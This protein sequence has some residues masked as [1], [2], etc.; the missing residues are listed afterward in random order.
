MRPDN[1]R[2]AGL[3]ICYGGSV[4]GHRIGEASPV[5]VG[6]SGAT[7]LTLRL[8]PMMLDS[9]QYPCSGT[10]YLARRPVPV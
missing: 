5:T 2:L 9:D 10:D 8:L 4:A 6:S 3:P 7:T 1:L